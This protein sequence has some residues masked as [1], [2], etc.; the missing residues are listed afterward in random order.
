[1]SAPTRLRLPGDE[2]THGD[3]QPRQAIEDWHLWIGM[4]YQFWLSPIP[5]VP[6]I[7]VLP[8]SST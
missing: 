4:G 3:T 8:Y 2:R 7:R 1:M 5:V 6:R